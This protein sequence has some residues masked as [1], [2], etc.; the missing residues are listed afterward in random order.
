MG[1]KG[2][3]AFLHSIVK[4]VELSKLKG[5]TLLIDINLYL[6]KHIISIKKTG[7]DITNDRG[8]NINH[9]ITIYNI[10][11]NFINMGINPI[12][13]FDGK[14]PVIKKKTIDKRKIRSKTSTEKI[15]KL[16]LDL[17]DIQDIQDSEDSQDRETDVKEMK[18]EYIK[19]FKKSFYVDGQI[20]DDC[21]TFL[22]M[23]GIPY[24]ESIG[25]A[26]KDCAVISNYYKDDISGILSEDSDMFMFGGKTLYKDIDI[27]NN[28]ISVLNLD[29]IL[30]YL[31]LK[32]NEIYTKNNLPEDNFTFDNMIDFSIILGNDYTNGIRYCVKKDIKDFINTSDATLQCINREELFNQF[33]LNNKNIDKLIENLYKYNAD[34]EEII[35]FIPA[36]FKQN[37][38]EAI[39]YYK[40]S[41]RLNPYDINIYMK[42]IDDK[43]LLCFLEKK[44]VRTGRL[45]FTNLKKTYEMFNENKTKT[46]TKSKPNT[47]PKSVNKINYYDLLLDDCTDSDCADSTDNDCVS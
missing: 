41:N 45:F 32:A 1:S 28:T 4:R 38:D 5:K 42:E 36:C 3:W 17:S 39:Y 22:D 43:K 19:H 16:F 40:K 13:V 47:K 11:K 30:E 10:I 26:D 24:V 18:E 27:H 12:C 46:K 14:P 20:I 33:I 31:Q 7:T 2:F 35:Y 44:Q 8:D 9:I 15:S 37:Y 6:Y 34:R 23:C 29:D 25:E 21:K